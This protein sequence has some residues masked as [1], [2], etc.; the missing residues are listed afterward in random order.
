MTHK[1]KIQLLN[2]CN[3]CPYKAT[4][5]LPY[6]EVQDYDDGERKFSRERTFNKPRSVCKLIPLL[7]AEVEKCP[8][9]DLTEDEIEEKETEFD[10][11]D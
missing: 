4:R 1:E 10:K 8:L 3:T 11:M 6:T 9:P 2:K 5:T 7:C